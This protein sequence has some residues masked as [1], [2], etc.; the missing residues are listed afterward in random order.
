MKKGQ[1]TIPNILGL[2]ISMF[3]F[4]AIAPT[5]I[6]IDNGFIAGLNAS[7]PMTPALSVLIQLFPMLIVLFIIMTGVYYAIPK[8]NQY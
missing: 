3:L 4:V 1:M 6:S 8:Q 7:D 2:V 5:I